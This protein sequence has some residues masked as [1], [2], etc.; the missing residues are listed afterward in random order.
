MTKIIGIVQLKGGAGR[1]TVATNLAAALSRKGST[2]IID[3]DIPQGTAASWYALRE[4]EGKAGDLI[5]STAGN[6]V[7]LLT[8]IQ[9]LEDQKYIVLDAPPRI[10]EMTRAI[11][12]ISDLLLIPL[13]PSAAEIWATTDLLQTIEE[14]KQQRPD[15]KARIVWNKYR[16]QTRSAKEL[17]AAVKHELKTPALKSHLGHRVGYSEALARGL[18]ADEWPDQNTKAEIQALTAEIE[19]LL[20][21]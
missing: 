2:A 21:G 4:S 15:L 10:A 3:C 17:S 1:S 7:E 19:K 6:H 16:P 20:R 14:A 13:T 8:E 12:M 11:L 9:K 18:A 5:L